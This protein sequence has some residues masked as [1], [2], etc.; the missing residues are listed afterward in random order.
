MVE[1]ATT[2]LV[3]SCVACP[4][5]EYS[6]GGRS[7]TCTPMNSEWAT[8]THLACKLIDSERHDCFHQSMNPSQDGVD[9]VATQACQTF[10]NNFNGSSY[11]SRA[12]DGT[13]STPAHATH[14]AYPVERIAVFHTGFEEGGLEHKCK[15][16]GTR[17]DNVRTCQ[18]ECRRG[19]SEAAVLVAATA[20]IAEPTQEAV[21]ASTSTASATVTL[22]GGLTCAEFSEDVAAA[23][24]SAAAAQYQVHPSQVAVACIGTTSTGR[25]LNTD[26]GLEVSITVTAEPEQLTEVES[27]MEEVAESPEK[28]VVFAEIINEYFESSEIVDADSGEAIVVTVEAALMPLAGCAAGRR[29]STKVNSPSRKCQAAAGETDCTAAGTLYS[30]QPWTAETNA[31]GQWMSIS[32]GGL[33]KVIGIQMQGFEGAGVEDFR[34]VSYV[35]QAEND[36]SMTFTSTSRSDSISTHMF[37]TPIEATDLRVYVQVIVGG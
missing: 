14:A 36:G 6:A 34:V 27:A 21:A 23:V 1:E 35:S 8:C 7:H 17:A 30:S 29:M 10:S 11:L 22:G 13:N 9:N 25:R 4:S 18:C 32:A 24:G 5:G 2:D 12:S 15:L 33:K 37:E 20:N 28:K 16:N 3:N 31:A 19:I 26:T